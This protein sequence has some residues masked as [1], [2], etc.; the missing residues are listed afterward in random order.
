MPFRDLYRRQ[1][2]LLVRV[3]PH[4]A[5][6]KEF[7]LKG[8]TAINLFIR[9]MPRLSVDIDLTYLP[10]KERAASLTAI[11]A[12]LRRIAVNLRKGIGARITEASIEG[13]VNKLIVHADGVQ[14]KIEVNPVIRGSIF[15]PKVRAVA[16]LVE[17][18]FGFAEMQV[19]STPDLYAG[20]TVAGL[21]RQHPRD[22]FDWRGL[23]ANEGVGDE[24]RRAFLVY[25][26]SHHRPMF[27]VL[28]PH[29][30]DLKL[31]FERDF[32]GMTEKVVKF[33]E[34]IAAREALISGMVGGM[35]DAH[36]A[37]LLSF[38]RGEPDWKTLGIA[39]IADLPAVK[40]RQINLAK[41]PAAKRATLVTELEKALSG[42]KSD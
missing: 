39:H 3:L 9:N 23:L 26:I 14:I 27:E 17:K 38:E 35:P 10:V 5:K 28:A 41:I 20:K 30:K 16:P 42:A 8:G 13:R 6:E 21:D 40:W 31:L 2:A 15:G 36:K 33:E 22:L 19:V 25:M 18:T 11:E 1:A 29:R 32:D 12:A 4:V 7:A 37:F 34:L 24:L